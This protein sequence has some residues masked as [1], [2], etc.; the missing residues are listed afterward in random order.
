MIEKHGGRQ[1]LKEALL[2]DESKRDEKDGL[3]AERGS[4]DSEAAARVLLTS[5]EWRRGGRD[6]EACSPR[7]V[8]CPSATLNG[9]ARTAGCR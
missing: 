3:K 8:G 4:R 7:A 9:S 5:S 6:P 2:R 1:C